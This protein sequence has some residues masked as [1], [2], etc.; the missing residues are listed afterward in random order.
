[1]VN[2]GRP[3]ILSSA[4]EPS[5]FRPSG[6]EPPARRRVAAVEGMRGHGTVVICRCERVG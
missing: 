3:V 4:W 2:L 6:V 5:H 1:M